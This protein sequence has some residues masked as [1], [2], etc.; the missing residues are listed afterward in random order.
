MRCEMG[1]QGVDGGFAGDEHIKRG[2]RVS[3]WD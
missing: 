1:K 2:S 3:G